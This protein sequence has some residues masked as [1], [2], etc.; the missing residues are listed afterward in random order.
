MSLNRRRIFSAGAGAAAT[1]GMEAWTL[2]PKYS[3]DYRK[4]RSRAAVLN[5]EAYSERLE[6]TML[7]D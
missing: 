6:E 1:I 7:E 5:A 2:R 3:V 4:A